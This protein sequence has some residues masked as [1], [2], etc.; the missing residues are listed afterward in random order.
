[1]TKLEDR[2]KTFTVRDAIAKKPKPKEKKRIKGKNKR[3]E[4]GTRNRRGLIKKKRAKPKFALQ[5]IMGST[6][7]GGS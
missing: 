5:G 6:P 4:K 1:V 3:G 7:D 2:K